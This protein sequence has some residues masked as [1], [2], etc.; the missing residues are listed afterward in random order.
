MNLERQNP[1][2]FVFEDSEVIEPKIILEKSDASDP[3]MGNNPKPYIDNVSE[4]SLAQ[5]SQKPQKYTNVILVNEVEETEALVDEL[6]KEEAIGLDIETT[7][8][9]PLL[10]KIR[11]VQISTPRDTY[12]ID[13]NLVPVSALS[14]LLTD[15]PIKVI[16][17]A[18]FDA[19][20]LY[21][22]SGGAM[23]EPIYDTM[24]TDQVL[25]H[26]GYARSLKVISKEYLDIDLDKEEQT[27]NWGA[28]R[29]SEAQLQYAAQDAAVLLP[30][31][32][33]LDEKAAELQITAVVE[34]ENRLVPAICW[35]ERAGVNLDRG[36]WAELIKTAGEKA[37]RLKEA[38]NMSVAE[39]TMSGLDLFGNAAVS[40][41]WDSPAQVKKLLSDLGVQIENT[42]HATLEANRGKHPVIALLL[43]YREAAKKVSTYGTDWNDHVNKASNRIHPNWVQIGSATGRTSCKNPNLQNIPR[44]AAYRNC[45]RAVSGNVLIKADYEQIE[46]RIAAEMA[47]DARMKKAFYD[48]RDLHSVTASY[49]LG[50]P[51][52][53]PVTDSQRQ[54][55]KAVNFGLIF[56]MGARGLSS[57]AQNN[58]QIEMDEAAATT[59]RRRYFEAY[60]GIKNWHELQS[61]KLETRTIL[62]RHRILEG[63]RDYTNRLNSPIQGSA[64]DGLKLALVKL[65]ETRDQVDACPVLTVHDEIVIEAPKEQVQ[66]A[67]EW[68]KR[69]MEEGMGEF[70]RE[71]P[72]A[73]DISVK[74]SWG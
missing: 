38:L 25:L 28:E 48:G 71:V 43:D 55:A 63:E 57:Y 65:W 72:V 36:L 32:R 13:I 44:E 33:I 70:L 34:L 4:D 53:E 20:F 15:G 16:H 50:K 58:F 45:F 49:L 37:L 3:Y 2:I 41:N 35:M 67:T 1:E 69:C 46:L 17:N 66:K 30:I 19:S 39:H 31:M 23:P 12:V 8:L 68:L 6:L 73:V 26:Q 11:L 52:S 56:G 7:G 60:S 29:L 21:E 61:K 22:A 18:K 64:A 9:D 24:I 27:S 14:P 5:N 59:V 10:D 74:E 47:A 40:V 42:R 54:M 62:G 51:E